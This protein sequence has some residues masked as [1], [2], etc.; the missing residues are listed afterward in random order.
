MNVLC[1]L[2]CMCKAGMFG[3][4]PNQTVIRVWES[5]YVT[6]ICVTRADSFKDSLVRHL[7]CS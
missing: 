4:D 3:C 5:A 2:V 6:W 1:D 7:G